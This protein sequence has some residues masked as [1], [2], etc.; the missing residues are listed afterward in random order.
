MVPVI[1]WPLYAEQKMNAV[2]LNEDLKV[3]L[4]P[5]VGENGM[6]GR[7]EIAKLVKGLIE[8]EEGKGL[9]T[10]MRDLKDA[11]VKALDED[12]SSTK[13]MAQVVSKWCT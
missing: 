1:A 7:V 6:V 4:R 11:A 5:Q 13:A 3:A 12:G 2:M 9:R 8:G 10:R